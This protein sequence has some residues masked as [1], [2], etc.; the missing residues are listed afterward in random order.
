VTGQILSWVLPLAVFIVV[1]V[2]LF[3]V[4]RRRR[5]AE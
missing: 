4:L 3:F 5:Q 1:A 2:W